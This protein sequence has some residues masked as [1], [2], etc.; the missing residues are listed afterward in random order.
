[1]FT[2]DV[3]KQWYKENLSVQH[4]WKE[5]RPWLVFMAITLW[6][7]LSPFLFPVSLISIFN[8]L[9][10]YKSKRQKK[11]EECEAKLEEAE[12]KAKEF[13]EAEGRVVESSHGLSTDL[14]YFKNDKT[15]QDE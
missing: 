15:N 1:M 7:M 11:A 9:I 12:K 6:L 8:K 10:G 13:M 2:V 14:K 3:V 5:Y 4:M